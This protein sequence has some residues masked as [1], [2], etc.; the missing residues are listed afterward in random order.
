MFSSPKIF[1]WEAGF[2]TGCG[3][4]QGIESTGDAHNNA[5]DDADIEF[6]RNIVGKKSG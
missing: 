4:R 2:N 6:E 5:A 3:I 1:V